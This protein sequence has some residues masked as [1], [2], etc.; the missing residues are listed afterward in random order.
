MNT[1]LHDERLRF[2]AKIVEREARHLRST[3]MRLFEQPFTAERARLLESD[4]ALA[5]RVDAFAARFSRLQDTLADKLVPALLRALQE[6][7][8]AGID[9][10]DRAE[11]LEWIAS[12]DQWLEARRLRNLMI[13]EYIDDPDVLADA[14]QRGHAFVPTLQAAAEAM[15]AELGR[16]GWA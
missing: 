11:R 12:V 16:R 5:E 14:L 8:G 4:L 9:N 3:D 2:L 13:H 10:L 15:L 1:P 7:V 6:P